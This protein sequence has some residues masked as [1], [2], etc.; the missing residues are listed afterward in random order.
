LPVSDYFGFLVTC[1]LG[2][3]S[4]PGNVSW[5]GA[6]S[7]T[8]SALGVLVFVDFVRSA[9][10]AAVGLVASLSVALGDFSAGA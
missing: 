10:G 8:G 6:L 4:S 3:S 2:A 1:F 5:A 9:F 7:L